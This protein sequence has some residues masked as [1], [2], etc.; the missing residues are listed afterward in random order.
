MKAQGFTDYRISYDIAGQSDFIFPSEIGEITNSKYNE[1]ALEHLLKTLPQKEDFGWYKENDYIFIPGP[2]EIFSMEKIV[3]I[4]PGLFY[5][6]G[7]RKKQICFQY[8]LGTKWIIIKKSVL[9]NEIYHR[10][11][12]DIHAKIEKKENISYSFPNPAEL[13]WAMLIYKMSRKKLL[14]EGYK[15]L[16]NAGDGFD[17]PLSRRFPIMFEWNEG[18][19]NIYKLG[20]MSFYI[21]GIVLID[22][23]PLI[24]I[25]EP[26]LP[27]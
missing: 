5:F 27:F 26:D 12:S 11:L 22:S 23:K 13:A 25:P 15:I 21:D 1:E 17:S 3:S 7:E 2:P 9:I 20:A 24:P 18:K 19:I 6:D 8:S 4:Q 10:I 16:S 14:L